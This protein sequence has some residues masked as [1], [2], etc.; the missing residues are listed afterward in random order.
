MAGY[1]YNIFQWYQQPASDSLN[2]PTFYH[3]AWKYCEGT[4]KALFHSRQAITEGI[5]YFVK[6]GSLQFAPT[7]I[8]KLVFA[9]FKSH[10]YRNKPK[11]K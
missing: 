8:Q 2:G 4:K 3:S 7:K 5:I 9:A 1:I 11:K 10:S 6:G